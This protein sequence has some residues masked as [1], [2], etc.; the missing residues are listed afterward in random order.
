MKKII[1]SEN[2]L[3][4]FSGGETSAFMGQW[5]NNHYLELGYKNIVFVFANTGLENEETLEFVEKCDKHFALNV[6]WIEA[7]IIHMH[8]KGT[9]YYSTDFNNA[10]RKGEPF[11]DMIKKYGIPNTNA[12]FCTRELKANPIKAFGKKYF[13][14]QKYHT[15]IGIRMDEIDRINPNSKENGYIYPLINSKMIPSTKPVINLYWRSMPFRLD[16]KGYQGNCATCWKKSNKKLYQIAKETPELF[17]F[18]NR[19]EETYG[20]YVPHSIIQKC[21]KDGK[22]VPN[23]I[24]FF[25]GDK[26]A[27]DI[28]KEAK[29]WNGIIK[30]DAQNYIYQIDLLGGESCEVFSECSN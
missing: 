7:E 22:E 24:K 17:D 1:E 9:K 12:P 5:L 16:L 13:N 15:A 2:L 3:V 8:K 28:L 6:Q 26:S 14:G 10:S 19:M 4:S 27:K 20:N 11:E 29:D 30:D 18:M 25:R 21:L 23:N